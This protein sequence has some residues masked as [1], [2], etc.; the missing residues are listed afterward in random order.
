VTD[1]EKE[2]A[3]AL[4]RCTFVPATPPKRFAR[5]MAS[6]AEHRPD[7]ELTERQRKYLFDLLHRFRRQIPQTHKRLCV[8][9]NQPKEA[10]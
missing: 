5:D 10:A 6:A 8:T 3:K 7:L 2:I 9:C 4:S 1:E